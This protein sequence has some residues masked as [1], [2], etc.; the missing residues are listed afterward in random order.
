[1]RGSASRGEAR[2][3]A[4]AEAALDLFVERG[5]AAVTLEDVALAAG[6]SKSTLVKFF[7]GRRGLVAAALAAEQEKVMGPLLAARDDP[8]AFAEAYQAVIFSP[9]C[10]ALLR[11]VI[12]A[13]REDAAVGEVFRDVVLDRLVD[14]ISPAVA[15]SAGLTDEARAAERAD[16]FLAVLHGT[17]LL[18]ALSGETPDPRRLA[19]YRTLAL[20][21]LAPAGNTG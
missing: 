1:V 7:G 18:R 12:G 13:S 21:L 17:E 10:L 3:A 20:T 11:F 16:Q 19:G 4:L 8:E 6:A 9:G 5:F 14:V 2:K 15:R